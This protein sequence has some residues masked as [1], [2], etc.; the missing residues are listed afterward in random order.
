MLTT[1]ASMR[2]HLNRFMAS[3]EFAMQEVET[4][5]KILRQEFELLNRPNPI[6]P[7]GS[8]SDAAASTVPWHGSPEPCVGVGNVQ[9]TGL[10][11]RATVEPRTRRFV[12]RWG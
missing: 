1:A 10:E 9:N 7:L 5:V 3:Y 12:T 2:R 6:E 11:T 4:K 8:E